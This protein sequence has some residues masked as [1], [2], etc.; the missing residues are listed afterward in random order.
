MHMDEI[1]L[2]EDLE[3]DGTLI[4][5]ALDAVGLGNSVR[6]FRTGGKA[7]DFFDEAQRQ[8]RLQSNVPLMLILDLIL[9]EVSGWELLEWLNRQLEFAPMVRMVISKIDDVPTIQRAYSLGVH[10]YLSKP[11]LQY[12]SRILTRIFHGYWLFSQRI[13]NGH[14]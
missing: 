11:T 6:H 10:A 13:H 5:S 12:D 7:M 9:P 3:A 8:D 4:R 2:V 14:G 1:V